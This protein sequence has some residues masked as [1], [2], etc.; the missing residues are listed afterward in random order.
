M[1][2]RKMGKWGAVLS[3][4]T[5]V[6]ALLGP[7]QTAQAELAGTGIPA[8]TA[9]AAGAWEAYDRPAQYAVLT[10]TDVK[11]PMRDG[12]ILA[13]NVYRP[14][15]PGTFP[16]ILTQTPYNKNS[17]LGAANTFLVERGYAH[18]VVD[19]RGTGGSQGVWES[20][21]EAEQRDGYELVE[22]AA[23]QPWSD[24]KVGL[25]GAS[26]MA[27]N[28]IFTAAQQPPGLK[29]IFPIVP[30][31]DSYRDILMSGGLVNTGFIPLWLG[32][33]TGTSLLPPTYTLADP[34]RGATTLS[35]HASQIGNFQTSSLTSVLT[36]GEMAYDGPGNKLRSPIRVV[37]RVQVP[38]FVVGGL[39]DIFQRG[40]P[41]LYEQLKK[42]VN[43]K[44]LIGNWTHGDF[45]SGLPADGVPTLNQLALRWFDFYL[46]GIQTRVDRI[47]AVTQYVLGKGHFEVQPDWPHPRINIQKMYLH[48]NGQLS[49]EQAATLEP[50]ERMLQQP[51]N[52]ICS[53][54]A[55]QW[56]A[57]LLGAVPCT[58]DNRLTELTELTYTTAPLK[59]DLKLSGPIA[60]EVYVSTTAKDAV[61]SVRVTDVAPDGAS[62]ELTA[63]WL[64]TSFRALDLAKSRVVD[65]EILQPWHPFTRESVLPVTPGEIMPLNVEIFPTNAVI[66]AGHRLRVAI[67][68]SDFPHALSPLPQLANQAGGMVQIWHGPEYPSTILLPVVPEK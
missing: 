13:A 58:K 31:A 9:V 32:L 63:G 64:A 62:T 60:A 67:G 59:R 12:V 65:G 35:G 51:V 26:Y 11:I 53:G 46:K 24:G 28:Q 68:P 2:R 27:I 34:V 5:G 56:T 16:V 49:S 1:N 18:V 44:L 54:S 57:G 8:A 48:A 10:E 42:R 6:A 33:V 19:V 25:W 40:E 22:W 14:N 47:P 66:P 39:H 41:L 23:R 21:G 45:G 36:G 61:L 43:A 38:A 3:V 20:F 4:L 7:G 50:S 30:M 29:A 55:N 17:P 15:A 52:G 37:D